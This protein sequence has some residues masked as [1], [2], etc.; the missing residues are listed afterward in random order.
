M[1]RYKYIYL[2][3][4]TNMPGGKQGHFL[5]FYLKENMRAISSGQNIQMIQEKVNKALHC[6]SISFTLR[7]WSF[8]SF[9][10]C[11]SY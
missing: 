11:F 1:E 2:L 10:L 3:L 5:V 8:Y 9:Y 6:F 4:S 7:F